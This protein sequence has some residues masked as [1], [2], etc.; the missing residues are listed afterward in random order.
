MPTPARL[1]S[2]FVVL[3]MFAATDA[4]ADQTIVFLRHGEKPSGG[5]GQ[6]TCQGLNRALALPDVLLAK[7]G[8]PNYIYAPN[9][10]VKIPDP[11]GSF[12]YIR[13]LATIEP[14][15]VRLGMNVWTKYGY[16][17]I[18]S[19]KAALITP[20]KA[21]TTT[22]VAWEHLQLQ[23]VVQNIMSAH[24]GG[25]L[26]PAWTSGDYDSLYVVRVDYIGSTISA[27]FQRDLQG[28]NGQPT[29]CPS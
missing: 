9:P 1:I 4:R 7:Y 19:L 27:H 29:T 22:F 3:T 13:P 12:Y 11:A 25:A 21:N 24:G 17:D 18:A 2:L 28:L 16:N 15:A 23:K 26:V 6:I 5:Y 14:T 8:K 20:N 10:T